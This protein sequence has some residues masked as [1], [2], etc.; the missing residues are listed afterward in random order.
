MAK[1]TSFLGNLVI[2]SG[3]TASNTLPIPNGKL[4]SALTFVGPAAF[5]GT[6]GVQ[7]GFGAATPQAVVIDGGSA[8]AIAALQ[9]K[10]VNIG[11]ASSVRVVS[12]GAEAAERTVPVYVEHEVN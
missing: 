12:G 9:S 1:M 11:G 2:A 8:I 3:Q 10:R 5:T 6:V 7:L 4:S